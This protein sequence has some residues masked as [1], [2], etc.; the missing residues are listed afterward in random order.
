M[1][2]SNRMN[3]E[4]QQSPFYN[5]FQNLEFDDRKEN[6]DPSDKTYIYRN[7]MA[8]ISF[9]ANSNFVSAHAIEMLWIVHKQ[10]V[11]KS[12]EFTQRYT[13][14]LTVQL[15]NMF[16]ATKTAGVNEKST[17][18]QVPASIQ[19]PITDF[20]SKFSPP[21]P[22]VVNFTSVAN[23]RVKE[24]FIGNTLNRTFFS[25][26]SLF[27]N[28]GS[29]CQESS[30]SRFDYDQA[31]DQKNR[32][33]FW[34]STDQDIEDDNEFEKNPAKSMDFRTARE[35]M[36]VNHQKK[37]GR[38]VGSGSTTTSVSRKC[39]GTRR[40]LNSKFVSPMNNRDQ[41][42]YDGDSLTHSSSIK[43]P[44]V[45]KNEENECVDERLKGIDPKIIELIMN[46]IMDHGPGVN[47]D[48]IA[49]LEFAKKNIKEIVVWPMLRPD[50]FTGL[51]G[52][53]KGLLLFGPPG[54]G[55]TLIGKCIAS[56]SKSTFFSISASSLTSKWVG[57]GEKTV[58]ALFAVARCHQPTVIFIDEIDS[59]LSQRNDNEHESS[60]R[61]K[62]EFLVQLNSLLT[63]S[64]EAICMSKYEA[65]SLC[66]SGGS[67]TSIHHLVLP[68]SLAHT[69]HQYL[70][71]GKF[72]FLQLPHAATI[73]GIACLSP[74]QQ[75]KTVC[76]LCN[77]V[78]LPSSFTAISN[79]YFNW[80]SSQ[81]HYLSF[82]Y[83]TLFSTSFF[84]KFYFFQLLLELG[85]R[86]FI[87]LF[88]ISSSSPSG[89]FE[90]EHKTPSF[91]F[92]TLIQ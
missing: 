53:P 73:L 25:K 7:L 57:E 16:D 71:V 30:N 63:L 14:K 15:L 60:R 66:G 1:N 10:L 58:R 41:E 27:T 37:Y 44:V 78:S 91:R 86:C 56:Q 84:V 40:G 38:G 85:E 31:I 82:F 70:S 32:H 45:G 65:L 6:G 24:S 42:N 51:R 89:G 34:R 12:Q 55:K 2:Y 67:N 35:Q 92:F 76:S 83:L 68:T 75:Q 72:I 49:G 88:P 74:S 39:L 4:G 19:T 77:E 90:P 21:L 46:E 29:G 79:Y 22:N 62:T 54:T 80:V 61:I 3:F 69:S 20:S 5:H 8:Q 9:A 17:F 18:N 50:I 28:S 47:W 13:N 81:G 59:L 33:Q 11:K 43:R 23:D 87:L 48:D 52:P 26:K 36:V 64:W